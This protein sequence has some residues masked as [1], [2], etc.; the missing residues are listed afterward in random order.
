[1]DSRIQT[2]EIV[3]DTV[4]EILRS[5]TPA[6]RLAI[7]DGMW[8]TARQMICAILARAHSDW[9]EAEIDRH[10]AQRMSS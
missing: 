3:D 5:K 1:M 6:E 4:A 7:A 9:S 2:I 10:V 8:K